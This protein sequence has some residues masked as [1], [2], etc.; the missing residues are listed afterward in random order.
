MKTVKKWGFKKKKKKKCIGHRE[1]PTI[2]RVEKE[3]AYVMVH[4][5]RTLMVT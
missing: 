3:T 2:L 5:P 1:K 4:F